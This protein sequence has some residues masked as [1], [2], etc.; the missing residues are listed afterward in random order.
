[1]VVVMAMLFVA[2]PASADQVRIDQ[3]YCESLALMTKAG[4][5][6]KQRGETKAQWRSNLQALKGYV[7]KNKD[8]V[9]YSIL[10]RVIEDN[11]INWEL[12]YT[13]LNRYLVTF[14]TCM[15]KDFDKVVTLAY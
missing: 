11:E 15:A 12:R 7:V 8:N 3:N 9:L 2:V 4:Q 5:E 6:A 13:P 1:M 10:P 14:N